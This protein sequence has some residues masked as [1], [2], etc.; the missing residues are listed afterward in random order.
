MVSVHS[1]AD[2][3]LQRTVQQ[4]RARGARAGVALNPATPISAVEDLLPDLDHVLVMSVNPG[5]SGQKFIPGTVDKLQRLRREIRRRGL[6][7]RL[8]VDGGVKAAN[9]AELVRAG[10]DI[11][12]AGSAVFGASDP[13]AAIREMN[14]A[15]QS[16]TPQ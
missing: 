7:V 4:I 13:A 3:H 12:V 1:E 15:L 5:F 16:G 9:A 14:R 6:D 8:E 10:A 2:R 11:L